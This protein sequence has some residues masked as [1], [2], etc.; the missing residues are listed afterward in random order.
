MSVHFIVD[1]HKLT[2]TVDAVASSAPP[3][4]P[5]LDRATT[6]NGATFSNRSENQ[7]SSG[8]MRPPPPRRI[9]SSAASEFE[10]AACSAHREN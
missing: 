9:D 3:T 5:K 6:F 7:A 2:D 1:G 8:R 10:R 4:S